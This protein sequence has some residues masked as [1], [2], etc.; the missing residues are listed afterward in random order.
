[1]K[2]TK[3]LTLLIGIVCSSVF[4]LFSLIR[5]A[6]NA[7]NSVTVGAT[8]GYFVF[9]DL[10]PALINALLTLLPIILLVSNLKNK[11]RTTLPI[12]CIVINGLLFI[13]TLFTVITPAIPKYLIYSELGL[14]DTYFV[15]FT[16]FFTRGKFLFLMEYALLMIGSVLSLPKKQNKTDALR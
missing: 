1:M 6:F 16:H 2:N 7:V 12:I 11:T 3:N 13:M 8:L 5:F 4:V 10:I 15:T 14:I 9:D